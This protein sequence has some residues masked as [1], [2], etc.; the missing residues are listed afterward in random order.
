MI[1]AIK[2]KQDLVKALGRSDVRLIAELEVVNEAGLRTA[3]DKCKALL[4]Q[5]R[6]LHIVVIER[7]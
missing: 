4:R 7:A 5:Q 3:T 1:A 2:T 6:K